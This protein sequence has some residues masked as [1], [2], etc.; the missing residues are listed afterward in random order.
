MMKTV[1]K[2]INRGSIKKA[3]MYFHIEDAEKE[4]PTY[5]PCI[6]SVTVIN[7]I[8]PEYSCLPLSARLVIKHHAAHKNMAFANVRF[9]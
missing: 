1:G 6:A 2:M 5:S 3:P 4:I 8:P 9:K 7:R